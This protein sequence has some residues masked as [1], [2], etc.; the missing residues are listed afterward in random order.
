LRNITGQ[1]KKDKLRDAEKK[2]KEMMK[3]SSPAVVN[4][5]NKLIKKLEVW[6]K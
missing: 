6:G 2:I 1:L 5:C 4:R 3:I